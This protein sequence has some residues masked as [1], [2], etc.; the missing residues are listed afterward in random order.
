MNQFLPYQII[1]EIHFPL[2][3]VYSEHNNLLAKIVTS[4]GDPIL[5]EYFQTTIEILSTV[6]YIPVIPR[7]TPLYQAVLPYRVCIV[8]WPIWPKYIHAFNP[9]II[10]CI[11]IY[12][13]HI[14]MLAYPS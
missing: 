3:M 4:F 8:I 14:R 11:R 1:I 9:H 13:L 12:I 10:G 2:E 6:N 7:L 5:Y